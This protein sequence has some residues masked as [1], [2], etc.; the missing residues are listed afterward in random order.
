MVV[1]SSVLPVL[2]FHAETRSKNCLRKSAR[3]PSPKSEIKNQQVSTI[4]S[5]ERARRNNIVYIGPSP[6]VLRAKK[7]LTLPSH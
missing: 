5:A 7:L 6:G 3:E 2:S 1:D 4:V